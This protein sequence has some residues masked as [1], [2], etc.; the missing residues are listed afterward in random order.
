[1]DNKK[2]VISKDTEKELRRVRPAVDIEEYEDTYTVKASVPGAT[3][4][5]VTLTSKDN[6]LVIEA[7]ADFT[8]LGEYRHK[9][10]EPVHYT[11]AFR[12]GKDID[13]EKIEATVN[14]GIL[15]IT[16]PRK[17]AAKA[18]QIQVS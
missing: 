17:E 16:L 8:E 14:D 18:R 10:F 6:E 4:E 12:L 11:R 2:Q 5:S 9:E 7:R 13:Q 15:S 3:K 1:M